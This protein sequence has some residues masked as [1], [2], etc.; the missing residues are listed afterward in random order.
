MKKLNGR[1]LAVC[2]MIA[3]VYTAVSLALAM[4]SFGTVQMR[5]AECLTLLPVLS[6]LGIYGVT[7]GCLLTNI[8]G[9]SLGLT[10]PL[11]ILFGTTATLIAALLTFWM[12]GWRIKSLA[13]PAALPPILVNGLVIG[14]ELTMLSGSFQ[15]NVFWTSA[16]S[17]ALGQVIP[18]LGL[19][20][21]LIYL[22]EKKGLDKRLF[23][24]E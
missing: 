2:A 12:R 10:I 19:G 11:D 15:W 7:V 9:V 3:A 5:V 6:P 16:G 18:C 23:R 8:I 17:V 1:D 4:A 22:L 24:K 14:L 13:I 20:V 21:L